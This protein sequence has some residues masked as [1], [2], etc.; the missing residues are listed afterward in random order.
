MTTAQNSSL[1][2][3]D[4]LSTR[5]IRILVPRFNPWHPKQMHQLITSLYAF[6]IYTLLIQATAS[7]I[8]WLLEIPP[9]SEEALIKALHAYIPGVQVFSQAK[10]HHAIGFY[11]FDLHAA[12]PYIGLFQYV[13]DFGDFDPIVPLLSAMGSLSKGEVMI[14]SLSLTRPRQEII[15]LGEKMLTTSLTTWRSYLTLPTAF[16]AMTRKA[17]GVD[18]VE[19]FEPSLQKLV[20]EK[21]NAPLMEAEISI[22]I[23]AASQERASDLIGVL[24]PAFALFE[25]NGI[26]FLVQPQ[27]KS[28]SL[29]LS[30]QEV[31]A[32]WHPPSEYCEISGIHWARNA[33]PLPAEL[34]GREEHVQIGENK[35]QD[36]V[37]S[38]WLNDA[39]RYAH[40]NILGMAGMGKSTLMQ[41]MIHQDIAAGN[42]V[43]VIDPHG[44]LYKYLLNNSIPNERAADVVLFDMQDKEYPVA[45]NMLAQVEDVPRKDLAGQALS[46]IRKMFADRWSQVRMEDSFYAALMA[47]ISVN[48]TTIESIPRLFMKSDYRAEILRQVTDPVALEYWL[49]EYETLP[50]SLKYEFARPISSRIRRFYRD[51]TIRNVVCQP[52]SLNFRQIMDKKTIFLANL[53]G[54]PEIETEIMG[55]SLISK[56]QTA[57]MSRGHLEQS[58]RTPFY[59]Y[60]DE[61]QRFIT[62]SLNTVF[63]EA[64]K[65]GLRM[66]VANQY[67]RQLAGD[68]LEA[69]MGNVG[70]TVMFRLGPQDTTVMVPFIKPQFENEDLLNLDQFETI[71]KMRLKGKTLPAFNMNTLPA[72]SLPEETR[73]AAVTLIE[74]SRAKYARPK[75]EVEKAFISRYQKRLDELDSENDDDPYAG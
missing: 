2:I 16:L 25:R 3:S 10:Q 15:D 7:E 53:G 71:V 8:E 66:T 55:A 51:E 18:E 42:A 58:E 28:Y 61:V 13:E 54:L 40:V 68:T 24:G 74:Q 37:S 11:R 60:I 65:F 38:V 30:P 44:D 47:L 63:S 19:R 29:V 72:L 50:N 67:L 33:T 48:G 39:D 32:F 17:M 21:M 46:I 75:E 20:T 31:A 6:P 62:T 1:A 64:R 9:V 5:T 57:A 45:L 27:P 26:N 35:F 34:Y 12:A 73:A 59:L 22:K 56:F 4:Q 69:I 36:K 23:K 14:Y 41:R 49:D 52:D 70:T 43:G